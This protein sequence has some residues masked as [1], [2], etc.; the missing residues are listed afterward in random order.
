MKRNNYLNLA[1]VLLCTLFSVSACSSSD[2]GYLSE[3]VEDTT[4]AVEPAVEPTVEPA[5]ESGC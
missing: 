2:P 3:S 1:I 4:T 5:V